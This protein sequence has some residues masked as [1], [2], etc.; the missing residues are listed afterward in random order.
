MLSLFS[1]LTALLLLQSA[2]AVQSE[3]SVHFSSPS[4]PYFFPLVRRRRSHLR[5]DQ[6]SMS[7]RFSPLFS[8]FLR[9]CSFLYFLPN[10]RSDPITIP[11]KPMITT[12]CHSADP[13]FLLICSSRYVSQQICSAMISLTNRLVASLRSLRDTPCRILA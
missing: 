13:I 4:H 7:S 5:L 3:H 9:F 6:Q 1:I 11:T 8:F 12:N 10:H 2:F